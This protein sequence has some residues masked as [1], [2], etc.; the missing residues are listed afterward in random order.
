MFIDCEIAKHGQSSNSP[1][2]NHI[3]VAIKD[4]TVVFI[5][6][7]MTARHIIV[8]LDCVGASSKGIKNNDRKI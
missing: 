6:V 5:I 7:F 4:C 8:S 1:V 3:S 2:D